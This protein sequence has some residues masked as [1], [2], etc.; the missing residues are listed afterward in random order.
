[1]LSLI[2]H[3]SC[4]RPMSAHGLR[5][6]QSTAA[7]N[8]EHARGAP[9]APARAPRGAGTLA[10]GG[11][12]TGSQPPSDVIE[13]RLA[14]ETRPLPAQRQE[15]LSAL[16]PRRENALFAHRLRSPCLLAAPRQQEVQLGSARPLAVASAHPD[17]CLRLHY[18]RF[19]PMY[20]N[21]PTRGT[22]ARSKDAHT[23][24]QPRHSKFAIGPSQPRHTRNVAKWPPKAAR[25]RA[26]PFHRHRLLPPGLGQ[27]P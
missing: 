17:T 5:R 8:G 15:H 9:R 12:A 26:R 25:T 24:P 16:R 14:L 11:T 22:R 23:R 20:R 13:A 1:M 2:A 3:A 18:S 27:R 10:G 4:A 21:T 7:P 19:V 6:A